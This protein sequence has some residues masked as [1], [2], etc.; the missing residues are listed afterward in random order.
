MT[1]KFTF[2]FFCSVLMLS[3]SQLVNGQVVE[4]RP[5]FHYSVMDAMRNGVYTGALRID[6]LAAQGNFGLGTYN[7]LDGE[8]VAL[9]GVFYRV[10][11]DGVVSKA[12]DQRKVPFASVAFFKADQVFEL[13][14]VKNIEMLQQE[15]MRRLPS[16]NKPYLIR[17]ETVFKELNVGGAN[18]L[19]EKDTTGL[20]ELMKSRPLYKRQNIAGTVVG[21]YHPSYASGIDLSPFH[22]HFISD[23]KSY[24]GHL[25]SGEFSGAKIKVSIDEKPGYQVILPP[26]NDLFNRPWSTP[27]QVKSSY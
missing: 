3:V 12:E 5:I 4:D 13:N 15:I 7:Q 20:A 16:R 10:A 18:K 14:N 27:E 22:F 2:P 9:D 1:R 25:V 11:P 21:F 26:D 17:I 8:M 19:A 23:D 6:A 24:G